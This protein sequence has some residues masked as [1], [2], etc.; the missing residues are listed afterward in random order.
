LWIDAICVN[1]DNLEERSHQVRRMAD[2]YSNASR[3]VA[4][5]GSETGESKL[6]LCA[7]G[8]IG[9]SIAV[10]WPQGQIETSLEVVGTHWADREQDVPYEDTTFHAI[11]NVCGRPWFTRFRIWQE[12]QLGSSSAVIM[13]GHDCVPWKT[14]SN[15][16]WALYYKPRYVPGLELFLV[17]CDPVKIGS[18]EDVGYRTRS[19]SCQDPKDR[20]FA[21][22][23]LLP[24][25]FKHTI[26]PDYSKRLSEIYTEAFRSEFEFVRDLRLLRHCELQKTQDAQLLHT[27]PSW[28]PDWS[29][30]SISNQCSQ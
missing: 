9:R 22:L 7:M 25:H 14:F 20:I 21:V 26:L 13:C 5:I 8:E 2:I 6:A 30:P 19:T 3:V 17:L 28:V 24:D 23:S 12:I 11:E 27:L 18:L 29:R 16:V 10:N 15:T 4:W 1:Q